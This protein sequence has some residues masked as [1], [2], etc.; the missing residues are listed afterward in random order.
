MYT[1]LAHRPGFKDKDRIGRDMRFYTE[2][3]YDEMWEDCRIR[4]RWVPS[5]LQPFAHSPQW[6]PQLLGERP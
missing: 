5:S 3:L 4:L 2:T 1:K 6:V